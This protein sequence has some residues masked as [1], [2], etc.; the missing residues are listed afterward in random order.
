MAHPANSV[1]VPLTTPVVPATPPTLSLA[2]GAGD[3]L[4][5]PNTNVAFANPLVRIHSSIVNAD[6]FRR[7]GAIAELEVAPGAFYPYPVGSIVEKVD[8]ADD[9]RHL[10]V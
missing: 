5:F 6:E 1:V 2:A 10:T 3:S 7:V 8:L 4:V 9:D